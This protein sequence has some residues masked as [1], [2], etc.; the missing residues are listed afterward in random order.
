MARHAVV[1]LSSHLNAN[2][3]RG[4]P[5]EFGVNLQPIFWGADSKPIPNRRAVVRDDTGE[6]IA[7]V[8]DRYALVQHTRVLEVIER[9]IEPLDVGVVPRGIYVDGR[10][11]RMRALYKFPALAKVV[12]GNDE[13]CP[14]IQVRNT[15]DSSARISVH[16]GA[17]RFVCTNL[18][19]GGGGAFAGGFVSIHAGE[20]PIEKMADE[21]TTYLTRF[22]RIVETYSAWSTQSL[23][24]ERFAQVLRHVLR[25]R[26][27]ELQGELQY[28]IPANVFDAYN[29][30]TYHAT[31][32]MRSAKTAFEMLE[33][34]NA[35]FQRAFPVLNDRPQVGPSEELDEAIA[36]H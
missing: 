1:D 4:H 36:V 35:Q 15:Y 23:D 14:C 7:V 8:S 26:F 34:V 33:R 30:L 16:I 5:A 13:I 11:A 18:A 12:R 6:A 22:D 17:F 27:D 20:I 24:A 32:A 10:G 3:A 21:L 25:G 28:A 29:R 19:V 31:H 2:V 9:A